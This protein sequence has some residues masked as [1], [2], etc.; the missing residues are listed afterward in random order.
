MKDEESIK[1]RLV[2]TWKLESY[3]VNDEK[4]YV[5]HPLGDDAEGIAIYH[6]DGFMSVQIMSS[7]RPAYAGG[8]I[9]VGTTS[10]VA[11]AAR[12]YLAYSGAYRINV[13]EEMVEHDMFV[14]LNPNWVGDTQPRYI[15]FEGDQLT[16]SSQPVFIQGKE[17][18]TKLVWRKSSA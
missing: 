13:E 10:G 16:I 3:Q 2:G 9:H 17:Q 6:Q 5:T 4:G 15:Q 11:A 14:S 18:N 1:E 12:G 7:G 8:D